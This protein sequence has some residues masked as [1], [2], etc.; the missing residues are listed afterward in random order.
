MSSEQYDEIY[1]VEYWMDAHK[2]KELGVVDYIIGE[3]CELEDILS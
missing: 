2:A 1:D 3:D